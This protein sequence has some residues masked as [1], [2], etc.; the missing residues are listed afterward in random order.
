MTK[1]DN[2]SRNAIFATCKSAIFF[3]IV[4]SFFCHFVENLLFFV[5]FWCNFLK[6]SEKDRTFFEK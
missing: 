1:N 2:A 3:V 6:N 5:S 4:L